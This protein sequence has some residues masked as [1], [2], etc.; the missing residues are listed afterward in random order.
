MGSRID[1]RH[2][3]NDWTSKM[4]RDKKKYKFLWNADDLRNLDV[5]AYDHVLGLFSYDHLQF[6]L[7]RNKDKE[8]SLSEM[9]EKAIKILSR[10]PNGFFL[11]VE[12]A[13]I[14]HGHH[15]SQAKISLHEFAEFDESIR[16]GL[17]LTSL[18]NTQITVTADHSHT[19]TIGGYSNRGNSIFG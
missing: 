8:P 19:F 7:L 10:N 12:G 17:K 6:E 16:V 2:L 4:E 9:T 18:N 3:I 15:N 14:D 1:N 13:R 11:L 5:N